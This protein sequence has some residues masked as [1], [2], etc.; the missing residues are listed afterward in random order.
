[1]LENLPCILVGKQSKANPLAQCAKY[2]VLADL[3]SLKANDGKFQF[4]ISSRKRDFI[5]KL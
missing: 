3:T 4:M 5:K 1:M 2:L